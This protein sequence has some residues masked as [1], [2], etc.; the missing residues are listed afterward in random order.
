MEIEA[1]SVG[2]VGD[3]RESERGIGERERGGV[4]GARREEIKVCWMRNR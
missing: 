2:E 1:Y 4:E 3:R